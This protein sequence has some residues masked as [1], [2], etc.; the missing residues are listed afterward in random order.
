M[1]QAGLQK[2]LLPIAEEGALVE[3]V[4]VLDDPK[5][6]RNEELKRKALLIARKDGKGHNSASKMSSSNG[7]S[8]LDAETLSNGGIS[9]VQSEVSASV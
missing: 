7:L 2:E 3:V 6:Q 9:D 8:Q 4:Q 5:K 1:Q